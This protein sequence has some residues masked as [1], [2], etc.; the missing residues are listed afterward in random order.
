MQ[1]RDPRNSK[2]KR[3]ASAYFDDDRLECF[4]RKLECY[5]WPDAKTPWT[6]PHTAFCWLVSGMNMRP[7]ETI[8]A[9]Y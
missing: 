6:L 5:F 9:T 3:L 2:P 8:S 4:C 7:R 1:A